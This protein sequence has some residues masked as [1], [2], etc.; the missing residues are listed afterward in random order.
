MVKAAV[1]AMNATDDILHT[2][3]CQVGRLPSQTGNGC[4]FFILVIQYTR[5]TFFRRQNMFEFLMN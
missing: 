5:Y 3:N 4:F 1:L 2:Q